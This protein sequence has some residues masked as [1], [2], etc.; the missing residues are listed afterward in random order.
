MSFPDYNTPTGKEITSFLSRGKRYPPELQHLLFAAN[1]WEKYNEI[2][3]RLRAG[4][5]IIIDRY[6][7]SNLAYGAANGLDPDW[8]AGLENGL[9]KSDIVIVLDAPVRSLGSRRS[10]R[11][12]DTYE[13][14]SSLQDRAK[15]AYIQLARQHGWAVVDAGTSVSIV[16]DRVLKAFREALLRRRGVSI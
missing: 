15:N 13:K 2:R 9:P 14:S 10:P 11:K 16:Q 5:V 8:L 12:K 3:A 6:T 1:R 4:D 7:E